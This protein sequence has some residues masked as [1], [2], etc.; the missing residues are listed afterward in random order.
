MARTIKRIAHD[1][2]PL[3]GAVT[4][5]G[6]II[7]VQLD[8]MENYAAF[9]PAVEKYFNECRTASEKLATSAKLIKKYLEEVNNEADREGISKD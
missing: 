3:S 7:S 5:L 8:A 2:L 4:E 9:D 6:S 1:L